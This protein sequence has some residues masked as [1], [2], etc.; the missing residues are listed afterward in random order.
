MLPTIK[1]IAVLT[2][3]GDSAGMN[4][5]IRSVVR[6]ALYNGLEID[7]VYRGYDGLV[8]NDFTP[9]QASSVS[10]IINRGGTFLYSARSEQ[11]LTAE[12]R[13]K[14]YNNLQDRGINALVVIGGD[15]SYTGAKVFQDEFDFPVIGLP[16]T[17]DNDIAG[18]DYTIGYDTA[19]NV[20][21]EAIDKIRDTATSHGRLFLVEV[22][23]RHAGYLALEVGIASGAEAIL[24]PERKTDIDGVVAGLKAGLERGKR[25]SI[26]VVA[27][28]DDAGGAF[29]IAEKI[30]GKTG[31]PMRVTVLGHLQRGGSP[32]AKERTMAS[33][34][35]YYAV[36]GLLDGKYGSA[37]GTMN[38]QIAYTPLEEAVKD[39]PKIDQAD[40]DMM[41][42]LSI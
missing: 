16:G 8:Q 30:E 36:K 20:A 18:T 9:M 4:P 42:A 40:L 13:Q 21:M 37:V 33:R 10:G 17:I 34:L 32:T 6:T 26:V 1:K 2:S 23:G 11:F 3:G 19:L 12:G 38:G 14:A 15:G 25:S 28:G 5:C 7:G 24:I 35:G 31:Y 39:I 27:E 41:K 22:M 29:E